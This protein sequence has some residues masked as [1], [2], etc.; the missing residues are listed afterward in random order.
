M[1]LVGPRPLVPEEDAMIVGEDR[2]RLAMRP[3]MTGVWQVGGAST[4]PIRKMV[5]LDRGY[6][7][8]WSLWLDLKLLLKTAQLVA[9]RRGV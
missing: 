3:G 7:E 1:S 5:V 2:L 6:L 8:G 4:I 9:L